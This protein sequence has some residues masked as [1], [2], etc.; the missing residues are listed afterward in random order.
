VEFSPIKNLLWVTSVPSGHSSPAIWGNRIFLS[1]FDKQSQK[2]EVL[3]L[4]RSNGKI[5]WRKTIPAAG[6]ENVHE[7][8]SPATATPVVDG[9]R[10]Y[11]YFGSYGVIAFDL[12]GGERW[13]LPLPLVQVPYG[14]GTSPILAGDRLILSRDEGSQPS[15][16][17]IDRRT[18]KLIWNQKQY[19]GAA[20]RPFNESTPALWKDEIVIH[21]RN[22]VVGFDLGTGARK[23]WFTANTQG[24][25]SPVAGPD[26]V[27]VGTWFNDGEP[28]LRVSLPDFD[29]LVHQYDKDGDKLVGADEFPKEILQTRR[30]DMEG[31]RGA[32]QK[33]PGRNL[34]AFADKNQDGKIDREEWEAL[35]K[36]LSGSP[37]DHGLLAI[38]PGGK[39]D[40]TSSNLLWKEPRG[41]P[42]V[43][44]PL[45]YQGRVYAVTNGGTVSC[46]DAVTGKLVFRGR[47]GAPGG[48]FSSPIS[49]GGRIYFASGEGVVTVIESGADSIKV[50]ARND[51]GEPLF[52]T[53]AVIGENIY[54]RT[55][56]RIYAFAAGR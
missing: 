36:Q 46:M 16:L 10:V 42:E 15:L 44:M 5:L 35:L 24:A 14:S 9:E 22:E 34:F 32:D 47:L 43:P 56:T 51:L 18:G 53:P 40:V 37:H 55:P 11:A 38:G 30:I 52:A 25:G 31:I 1:A 6:I 26:A 49:A 8:S 33:I 17:A 28:D 27:Y 48:Y 23:W 54:V 21:H 3:S 50:L 13:T 20:R 7:I 39:G 29:T 2:L 45:Y 4:D 41:V 12:D 19:L